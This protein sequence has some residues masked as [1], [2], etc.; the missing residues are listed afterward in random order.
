MGYY[1]EM[2]QMQNRYYEEDK[3]Y[4]AQYSLNKNKKNLCQMV[5]IHK[6]TAIASEEKNCPYFEASEKSSTKC[7]HNY[8]DAVVNRTTIK[9]CG[10]S[11]ACIEA[12]RDYD[13]HCDFLR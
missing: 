13:K 3:K 8:F 6:C 2:K 10:N 7:K 12:N 5:T 9:L 4:E 1:N 11:Q